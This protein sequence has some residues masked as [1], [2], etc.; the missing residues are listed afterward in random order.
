LCFLQTADD[1][2]EA[3]SPTAPFTIDYFTF[4]KVL[5]EGAFGKVYLAKDKIRK[6]CVAIKTIEKSIFVANDSGFEERDVLQL[7]HKCPQLIHGLG[8]F[9]TP[10]LLY[11]VMEP[12]TGGNL[13][14]FLMKSFPLNPYTIRFIT[15]ELVCGTQF[16]HKNHI[17][18]RD[19]KPENILLRADGHIKITDFGLSATGVTRSIENWC[20]G[21]PG[22]ISPEM[23]NFMPHG[24]GADYFSIGVIVYELC[25]GYL[26]FHAANLNQYEKSLRRDPCY[27]KFMVPEI[28]HLIGRLLC[29]DPSQ[30]LGVNGDIRTHP[31]FR[32][33]NWKETESGNAKPPTALKTVYTCPS[34]RQPAISFHDREEP[35]SDEDQDMFHQFSF[36]CPEWS[37]QYHPVII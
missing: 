13:R 33:I 5:G 21:T 16:L 27:P 18:H 22:Y 34:A 15:A 11:F 35:I 1:G 8:T 29:K 12:A 26:P 24:P 32:N 6:E 28:K 17:L 19:L 14:D 30:R 2:E 23:M 3:P 25:T 31:Y 37:Q 7:S 4:H 20:G 9:H 36:I 10:G